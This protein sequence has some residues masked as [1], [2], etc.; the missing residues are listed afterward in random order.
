MKGGIFFADI[1]QHD[2]N[3]GYAANGVELGESL[4]HDPTW[5]NQSE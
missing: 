4:L 5:W 3:D 2:E 1:V